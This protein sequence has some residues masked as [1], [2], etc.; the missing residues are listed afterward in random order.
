MGISVVV[1]SAAGR[2]L[3]LVHPLVDK[4]PKDKDVTAGWLAFGVFIALGLAV[5]FLGFSL[6][7]HL[8]RAEANL[9]PRDPEVTGSTE[10]VDRP[11]PQS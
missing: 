5:V 7:K 8:R 2:L 6:A 10:P 4:V 3:T 1:T 9:A 11:D